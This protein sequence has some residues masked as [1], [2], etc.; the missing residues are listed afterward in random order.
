MLFYAKQAKN[1]IKTILLA[2]TLAQRGKLLDTIL[3]ISSSPE[4]AAKSSRKPQSAFFTE[5]SMNL[6]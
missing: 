1:T 3:K 4:K 5:F 6:L 2:M